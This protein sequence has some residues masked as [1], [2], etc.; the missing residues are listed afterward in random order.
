MTNQN[1]FVID[2]GTGLAV[3]TDI[4]DALQALAG[5]SSGNSEPSVKYAYQWWADSNAA[6]MKLRN[7]ANDGWIE[8]FQLDG[9]LT[10]E[11][12][13][14]SAPALA[15]RSD[16]NTGVFFSAAD[17][18]NIAT[19]GIER[20]ELGSAT[21]FN[22]TGIDIDFRV[23]GVNEANLFYIDASTRRIGI[24]TS[25]PDAELHIKE[26]TNGDVAA[27]VENTNTGSSARARIQLSS[28]SST[29]QLYA[30]AAAYSGVSSWPDAGVIAT[31]SGAAGGL[32][33]NV[34]AA[35]NMKFQIQQ[36]EKLRLD[37]S[38]RLLLGT[39]T[40]GNGDG[41]EF[42]IANV[43]GANM[44]MTIRSGTGALGNLFFSDAT[45]GNAEFSGAVQYGHNNNSLRFL[46]NESERAR[47][48]NAGKFFI[49]TDGSSAGGD[50]SSCIRVKQQVNIDS[51]YTDFLHGCYEAQVTINSGG[52]DKNIA[53]FNGWDGGIHG[54]SICMMYDGG[55]NMVFG[56][57]NDTSDR[58][59]QR[60][61]FRKD[62]QFLVSAHDSIG[63][64]NG[65]V[66][67]QDPNNGTSRFATAG[68][69]QITYIQF[70]NGGSI[71]GSISG[72]SSSTS[73][74]TSSDYRLKENE[75]AI[76]DGITRLKQL[77]PYKFNWK[78]DSSTI[79][80]G[81]F[82]HEVSSIVPESITGTKDAVAVEDDVNK[83]IADA[84]GDPIY[85]SIDQGKLVPL[86]VAAVKEL[87]TKVETLEAA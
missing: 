50:A 81:F 20:L 35:A 17:K 26:S 52:Q 34:T 47:F 69:G 37:S 33:L 85:Q 46:A 29:L 11:D 10:L 14:A 66:R 19:G 54:V 53:L 60:G 87:I 5:N 63:G 59:V 13:S 58:P 22:E 44:G 38:G 6:V 39:T 57:N 18:F 40:E 15:N 12:G 30:T 78:S 76:T 36:N 77:K 24:I 79:V 73:Y 55:Y 68:S 48:N 70:I 8:L 9:T 80:D 64:S 21:I 4:Q 56:T 28:D 67:L 7:S 41:D 49:A 23:E 32:I 1:D 42:T 82:A 61:T 31:G 62:G 27:H 65:G 75:T 86:L 83:G 43:S 25:A 2:N 71:T 74:N 16:L 72:G 45:S 84:I 3:R 51:S